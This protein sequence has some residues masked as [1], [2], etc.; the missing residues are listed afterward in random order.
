MFFISKLPGEDDP[1]G[2]LLARSPQDKPE[3]SNMDVAHGVA[4]TFR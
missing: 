3:L 4:N 2:A 1:N